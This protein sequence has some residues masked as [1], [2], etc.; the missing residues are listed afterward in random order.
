M[1]DSGRVRQNSYE[2]YS[3]GQDR[4]FRINRRAEIVVADFWLQMALDGR[5]FGVDIATENDGVNS[6]VAIDDLLVWAVSDIAVGTVIIPCEAKV[7]VVTWTTSTLLDFMLEADFGK[8]RYSSGG[9]A[10]TAANLRGDYPRAASGVNRVNTGSN[11]GVTTSAKSTLHGADGSLEFHRHSIEVNWGNAG[12]G[13][14]DVGFTW[15]ATDAG[16]PPIIDGPG[17]FLFHLGAAV[18]VTAWG[19]YSYAELPTASVT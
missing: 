2:N 5:M 6:T 18:D 19:Y 11:A 15:R 8:Q 3:E 17:S 14:P 16:A 7:A 10:V 1:P 4:N 13:I 12:D 9:T